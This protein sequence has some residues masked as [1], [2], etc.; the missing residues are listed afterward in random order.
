MQLG[1]KC[2]AAESTLHQLSPYIGKLKSS[3]AGTL[4]AQ[5]TEADDLVYDPFSG[6]GTVALEAWAAGRNIIANDLSPYAALPRAK[7][8]PYSSLEAALRDIK[9]I[10][11]EG[12]EEYEGID[13]RTVP[14]WVR[15]FFHPETLRETLAWTHILRRRRRWFSTS[16]SSRNSA[17]PTARLSIVPEPAHRSLS[18]A[19]AFPPA[20]YPELY[21]YRSL[22]DR[23]EAKVMRAFRRVP[24]LDY[25]LERYC[26]SQSAAH[27]NSSGQGRCYHYRTRRTCA[28]STMRVTIGCVCGFLA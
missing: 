22:R 1:R 18:S 15:K 6:S 24:D 8:F 19:E 5:F 26:F 20:K 4:I 25:E 28:N 13:L 27:P 7:L 21:E 2:P 10:S 12:D 17:R 23:L 9:E 14:S 3:I 16:V 11:N